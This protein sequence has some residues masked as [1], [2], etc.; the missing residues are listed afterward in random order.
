MQTFAKA[1]LK[2]GHD[3]FRSISWKI[4]AFY[5]RIIFDVKCS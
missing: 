2:T 3:I 1:S 4:R 5:F